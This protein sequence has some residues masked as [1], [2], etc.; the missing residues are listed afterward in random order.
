MIKSMKT[1]QEER[2]FRNA[3]KIQ[4]TLGKYDS[5]KSMFECEYF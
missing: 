1:V 3:E 4:E 5:Y 2:A